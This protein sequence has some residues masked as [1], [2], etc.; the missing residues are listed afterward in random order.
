MSPCRFVPACLA[1]CVLA[2]PLWA[3][4]TLY[5]IGDS[6][7]RNGTS[8]QMGWGDPLVRHFD[9]AKIEV[10]NRAI[11][12]RSSRT[13]LTEGRWD[14]VMANLKKGDFVMM[15]FGHN[16]GGPLND[17]RCR[18]SIKGAGDD[19]E[20]IVNKLTG[21]PETVRSFGWY[22]RKYAR[23]TRAKGAVPV[24]VS[25]IPRNVWKDGE[26][27]RDRE[28]HRR[29]AQQVAAEERA[30]FVDFNY[31][32]ADR[33]QSL[34]QEGVARLFAGSD[35]THT[36]PEGAEFNAR[37]MVRAIR[38][39]KG[40][41]L[42]KGL[43]AEELWLPAV[44]S[45]HMVVQR[46]V[47]L[48]V[49]GVAVPGAEVS[50]KLGEAE[51]VGRAG[52][53]GRWRVDLP[54]QK[55]GGPYTLEVVSMAV[56]RRIR[57]VFCGD[58]WLCFGK[59]ETSAPP[60]GRDASWRREEGNPAPLRVFTTEGRLSEFP[61]CEIAG[62]WTQGAARDG[63]STFGI[64]QGSPSKVP[65]GIIRC[66]YQDCSAESW[67][68]PEAL[69]GHPQFE[70]LLKDFS[71]RQ[72]QFRDNPKVFEDFGLSRARR[73]SG[74]AVPHPDPVQNPRSPGVLH[75]GM[76]APLIPF[77]IHGVVW[78]QKDQNS[79]MAEP[80]QVIRDVLLEDWRALWNN[81]RLRLDARRGAAGGSS[82]AATSF[83][84]APGHSVAF[85]PMDP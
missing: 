50:V 79:G 37:V 54:V 7:V 43:L 44:F 66:V 69:R 48:P 73:N 19:S 76:I 71:R 26:I 21:K 22:L 81:P 5:I 55:A 67:I 65:V 24:I 27:S 45:D 30:P 39:L 72:I 58:V 11:G 53:D 6:T 77:A 14:A 4:P 34:G 83:L 59:S 23:D 28:G 15:Q 12:G 49:W 3:K 78:Q 29:W 64:E 36:S 47:P 8:G 84:D 35:H 32:L 1:I 17:G 61:Q 40:C 2:A 16:D 31:L 63:T 9:P 75:N 52:E 80:P 25:P 10:V 74:P 85:V 82:P 20:R 62:S 18:A 33:Y 42:A 46:D 56:T 41:H 38:D 60:A 68:R 57:D 13:F 51:A 70:N